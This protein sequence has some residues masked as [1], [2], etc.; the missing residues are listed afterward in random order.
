MRGA[1]R[2]PRWTCLGG[3]ELLSLQRRGKTGLATRKPDVLT[4][5]EN[6]ARQSPLDRDGSGSHN[7]VGIP[8]LLPVVCHRRNF[9]FPSS[10]ASFHPEN[11]CYLSTEL[12][13]GRCSPPSCCL[14]SGQVLVPNMLGPPSS[15]VLDLVGRW[16]GREA[17]TPLHGSLVAEICTLP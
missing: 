16:V 15:E 9:S 8:S 17:L 11:S 4:C 13:D 12:W 5:F 7:P 1:V 10:A 2:T 6:R 3:G 14:V